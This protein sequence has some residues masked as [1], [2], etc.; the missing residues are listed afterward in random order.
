MKRLIAIA[1]SS[2]FVLTGCAT[3]P[4]FGEVSSANQDSQEMQEEEGQK[5]TPELEPL[6]T[7]ELS[8]LRLDSEFCKFED[9]SEEFLT[10]QERNLP[11]WMFDY[12]PNLQEDPIFLPSLGELDVALVFV[13]WQDKKGLE[14]DHSYYMSQ[15]QLM[16]D[17]FEVV[18][19]GNLQ[20]KWRVSQDWSTLSG[21]WRD[22]YANNDGGL[23][24]EDRA[25]FEQWFLDEAVKASDESFD[26]SEIDYVVFAMPLS[27]SMGEGN[28]EFG[29]VVMNF[30]TEG[31]AFDVHAGSL[32]QTV[33]YSKEKSIGNW[34]ISGTAYQDQEG[35][36]PAWTHWAHEL[37]HMFGM[38]S[39]APIPGVEEQSQY[40]A[41]PMSAT[42]LFAHSWHPVR[43]VSTWHSWILGWI[44]DDQVLCV[45]AG[46]IEDEIFAVNSFR[47]P[48]GATKAVIV[49]TGETTGLVIESRE[50]DSLFDAPS[51]KAKSG[52]YDGVLIY[53]IDS[54]RVISD[55]SLI[56]LMPHGFDQIWDED[57]PP[58][59]ISSSDF[60]FQE[61]E[62]A[63]YG[64]FEIE[65]LSMQDG[66]DYVRIS[67][68]GG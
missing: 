14:S 21:S 61:G 67:K 10:R 1:V 30:G 7:F 9:Q 38:I 26:Y 55:E 2:L 63:Q 52:F 43:A 8:S 57:L 24:D 12:F 47:L 23:S 53:Y 40:F 45:D 3:G 68:L 18:S 51:R 59:A 54:S 27:G 19:Q 66:V 11:F 36:T 64:D 31:M 13:D 22:Y 37:G 65:V 58:W 44:D 20:V 29:E 46:E 50:W 28:E 15:A 34:V 6:P 41:N 4:E 60:M 49:R 39:H 17:W 62:S 16:S 33:V 25:P 48:N 35:F 56:P 32:R 5:Q 42:S